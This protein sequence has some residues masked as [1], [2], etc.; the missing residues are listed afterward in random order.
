MGF[1]P[2][3]RE[4]VLDAHLLF[5]RCLPGFETVLRQSCSSTSL[6]EV[7]AT[8]FKGDHEDSEKKMKKKEYF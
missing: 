8:N 4:V 5:P 1:L 2:L 6:I 3:P 7:I